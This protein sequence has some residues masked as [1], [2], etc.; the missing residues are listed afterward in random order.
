MKILIITLGTRGDVQPY[1]ALGKGL[2][3]AGH[4]VTL[5]T[6][7]AFEP[8]ITEHGLS[9]AYMNDEIIQMIQSS[10]GSE[11]ME[12]AD[13]FWGMFKVYL[14]LIKQVAPMQRKIM[15]ESWRAAQE[16]NPDLILFHVKG[17]GAPHFAEKL[18]VPSM[19]AFYLPIYTPTGAFP[20]AGFPN[21]NLGA[22]YNRLTYWLI[23]KVT[24]LA[25]NK[26]IKPWRKENG[27][28]PL[29]RKVDTVHTNA[30]E[31]IPIA[32]GYSEHVTPRPADLPDDVKV[33]GFWFLDRL[34]DW[35]P[36]DELVRFL[37]TGEPPVYV[38]FGS[39]SG[40][41]PQRTA[42]IVIEALQRAN[43]R[44]IIA[45][46]WGGLDAS[47]LPETIFKIEQAPHDWL[48]PRMA[49]V[50]H[51]GGVGTTSAG[52]RAGRPTVVCPFFGDQPYWGSRVHALGVGCKPIPQKKLTPENLAAA[53]REVT[54]NSD[55]RKNAAAL[56][57][58]IR[59]ENG[60]KSAV[61]FIEGRMR[62]GQ[63]M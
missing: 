23:L 33:T 24:A 37:D 42:E 55:I 6:C 26:Y 8:F 27:L 11:I 25:C 31:R 39:I 62:E 40:R 41:K 22:W 15:A 63:K 58:K 2:K 48:F 16:S 20:A 47:Q 1:V 18:G 56:G 53:I 50:V 54:T 34:D 57:E 46:G 28:P 61:K 17:L 10:T 14:R 45:T 32:Y 12:D 30:G 44:G 9:Y 4:E 21:W 43:V 13:N 38:G 3:S 52:L 49:A 36:P 19:M 29:S 7:A 60:V 35:Q 5:C 51:H 59:A